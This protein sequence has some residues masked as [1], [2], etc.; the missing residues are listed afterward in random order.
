MPPHISLIIPVFDEEDNLCHLHTRIQEALVDF[1]YEV[2]YINDG[3]KDGSAEV[4]NSISAKDPRTKIIHF[5]RNYGQTAALTAGIRNARS[6]ILITLDADLQNDPFDIP[7]ML[8]ELEH[9]DVV[10]GWRKDRKDNYWIRTL[11]SKIANG[12]ISKLSKVHLHDYGCTLRVYKRAYIHDIPL[13][14]EMHRFIPIY[15]TWAGATIKEVP[16]TH[17][18]R[19]AGYSK[20]GLWRIPKVLLDLT[21]LKF[22]RDFFVTPI[23][24]FGWVGIF[25][26]IFG[27]LCGIFGLYFWLNNLHTELGIVLLVLAPTSLMF[28][29]IEVTLGII[30]EVLIRMH[31]EIQKKEPYRIS[32]TRNFDIE[33]S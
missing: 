5:V 26:S 12:L 4:L 29:L 21:T 10:C 2:L 30:A 13:Y 23:Y 31:F 19:T 24:F 33:K 27:L 11:P 9:C 18:P 32:T 25:I 14:G 8:K 6:E 1:D 16:V 20:Y 15:V 28:A 17:H 3:S 22:L 7:K